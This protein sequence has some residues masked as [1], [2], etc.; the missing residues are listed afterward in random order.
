MLTTSLFIIYRFLLLHLL[1]WWDHN[2]L[3]I[4]AINVALWQMLRHKMIIAC[5][6]IKHRVPFFHLIAGTWW[7]IGSHHYWTLGRMMSHLLNCS[8]L[9]YQWS[10]NCYYLTIKVL[11][12]MTFCHIKGLHRSV[13]IL[14]SVVGMYSR[15]SGNYGLMSTSHLKKIADHIWILMQML[16]YLKRAHWVIL[17]FISLAFIVITFNFLIFLVGFGV[18]IGC[19]RQV[20]ARGYIVWKLCNWLLLSMQLLF[21]SG[22]LLHIVYTRLMSIRGKNRLKLII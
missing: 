8:S 12:T 20:T 6:L 10:I 5:V 11:I 18:G 13:W 1:G 4:I 2:K 3:A 14:S 21:I 16:P 9:G 17:R 15:W 22:C 7:Q 19:G